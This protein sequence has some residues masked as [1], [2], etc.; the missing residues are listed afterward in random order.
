MAR[1]TAK[2]IFQYKTTVSMS[3][4]ALRQVA[5]FSTLKKNSYRVMLR[6]MTRLESQRPVKVSPKNIAKE[7]YMDK[8]DVKDA[9]N[10]LLSVGLITRKSSPTGDG[11]TLFDDETFD[12]SDYVDEEVEPWSW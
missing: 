1:K 12:S 6:L 3:R 2:N 7:L 8:G 10:E 5:Q 4:A 11:C 9:L